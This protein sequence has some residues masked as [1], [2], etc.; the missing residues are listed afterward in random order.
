MPQSDLFDGSKVKADGGKVALYGMYQHG[1]FYT[2]VLIGGGYTNYD[3]TRSAFLGD[4]HGSTSG[5]QFDAYVG[6]G[7][8]FRIGNWTITPMVSLLYTWVGL[9][10]FDEVGSLVPLN[11]ETQHASS[12]R[13]RVG[14]RV[15]YTTY[16]G[17][18]R[19]TR[20]FSA[21]WQHEFQDDALPFE[22]RFSNVADSLFTVRGPAI[23]R[24]S[25]LLTAAL[26]VAWKRYAAYV[27]Y[28]ADLGRENYESQTALVGFRV[29]W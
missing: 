10:G 23:G 17:D 4:A 22:A 27:A 2:E 7:Y 18:A 21:Q 14:P 6:T 29:S 15:A 19:I 11:V 28:Q 1:G 3:T 26:S 9:D 20:S 5:V 12:L 24:D 25:L 16:W 8:D 13:I